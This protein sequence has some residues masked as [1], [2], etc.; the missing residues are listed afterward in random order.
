MILEVLACVLVGGL[1]VIGVGTT[2][3]LAAGAI[4]ARRARGDQADALAK[5]AQPPSLHPRVDLGRCIGAGACTTVCPEKNVLAV[6][7][8]KAQVVNPTACI[9]HGEC[10]RACPVD[11]IELVLGTDRRGVDIP[12][13][14]SDFQTD[15]PGLYIVGELGGMGLVFNA[16]NQ[17][18]QCM[19]H[20]CADCPDRRAGVH[21]VAIVG[22]GP[23][24]IAA[25]LAA[26]D[27]GLDYVILEQESIGGTVLHYP[28]HKIVMTRPVQLPLYGR[29]QVT[30]VRKEALL[31]KWHD[32][33]DRT[34]LEVRTG[35]TVDQIGRADDGSFVL[36][37][38]AGPVAA[39]RV[40][41]AMGR[42]GTPRK[43]QIPGEEQGKVVYRLLDPEGYAGARCLVVGGGDAGVEAAIALGQAGAK[44]HLAHRKQVFDRIKRKNQ[45]KLD[46][47]VEGG[48]V[49]LL[50]TAVPEEIG[51]DHVVVTVDGVRTTLDN[52][53][54]LV[55]IGGVLPT[56]F[57]EAAGVNIQTFRGELYAPAN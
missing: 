7:D 22:A 55:F 37:T 49:Q 43:L 16:M 28:R 45:D 12:M 19:G 29:L 53:Y 35:V 15:V 17:A 41:L 25:G 1:L 9:G 36:A 10:L 38:S 32:I 24:G 56:K 31:D 34:G 40:V 18:L 48:Q 11:A 46:A 33:L 26:K 57:L 54:V 23:A 8:G 3:G 21:Q 30:E 27:A 50:L 51:T 44:V 39:E 2:G 5:G 4:R 42:R 52:D 14:G 13:V 47:A 20:L 6:L